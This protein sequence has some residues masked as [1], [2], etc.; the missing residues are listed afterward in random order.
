MKIAIIGSGNVGGALATQWAQAGHQI[1][2]GLRDLNNFKGTALLSNPSTSIHSIKEATKQAEVILVATPPQFAESLAA[3]FGHAE[4]KIIIDATN[5]I[6]TKPANYPTA[7][8]ALADLT[9]AELVKCFNST[10]F[11]NMQQPQY[12]GMSLDM[13][14][15]GDSTKAKKLPLSSHPRLVLPTAMTLAVATR[16]YY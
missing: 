16:S 6:R 8:H 7:Y 13:F 3:T 14:M 11:E 5:A 1:Y 15:A 10:G 12:E 9:K 2:L 4:H